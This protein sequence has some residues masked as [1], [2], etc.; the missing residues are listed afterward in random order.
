M[1]PHF[2]ALVTVEPWS[3]SRETEDDP[4]FELPAVNAHGKRDL[5]QRS[6]KAG[7]KRQSLIAHSATRSLLC[8]ICQKTTK[9]AY[10]L[11]RHVASKHGPRLIFSC[12]EYGC[13]EAFTRN[14]TLLR[15]QRT[16]HGFGKVPCPR[17]GKAVR[18]DGLTEH[19]NTKACHQNR[20]DNKE[21]R[22]NSTSSTFAKDRG[23]QHGSKAAESLAICYLGDADLPSQSGP[24]TEWDQKVAHISALDTTFIITYQQVRLLSLT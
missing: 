11:R 22:A 4:A 10:S 16:Q 23:S 20:I 12:D 3:D 6:A 21:T 1:Y 17:C 19:L 24:Q 18:G 14:D 8:P 2:S 5:P 9:N 15:H 7:T 13:R